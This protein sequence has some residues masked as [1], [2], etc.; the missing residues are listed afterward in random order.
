ME[1]GR[2]LSVDVLRACSYGGNSATR[3]SFSM[4]VAVAHPFI[5]V[6][7]HLLSSPNSDLNRISHCSI[8][9]FIS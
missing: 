1:P 2:D 5:T 9:G 6:A 4:I 8:K 3:M 7:Y